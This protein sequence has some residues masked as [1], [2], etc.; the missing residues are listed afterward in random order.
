MQSTMPL[1][2]R[3]DNAN[4]AI[5]GLFNLKPSIVTMLGESSFDHPFGTP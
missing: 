1:V 3:R 4:C 5:A 2:D